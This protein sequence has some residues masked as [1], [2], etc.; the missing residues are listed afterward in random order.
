LPKAPRY[1]LAVSGG[2][3]SMGLARL[4]ADARESVEAIA[5]ADITVLTVDHGLRAAAAEAAARV[6]RWSRQL[7]F[8]HVPLHCRETLPT[9]WV[10]AAARE[11]RYRL[12]TEW[13]LGQG[14]DVL[15]VAHTLDDQAETVLMRLARG[16]GVDGLSAM[17][18]LVVQ[19]GVTVA[20]PLLG[21]SRNDIRSYLAALDQPWIEDPSNDDV[22]FERVRVRNALPALADLG[23]TPQA[24]ATTARRLQRARAM[25]DGA[26]GQAMSRH[27]RAYDAGFCVVESALLSA[28]HEE[29]VLRVLARCL[30]AVGGEPY[31]PRQAALEGLLEALSAGPCRRTLAGCAIGQTDEAITITRE[32][33]R[34]P[35]QPLALR[36]GRPALWDRRFRVCADVGPD[37]EMAQNGIL[38]RPLD[39]QAWTLLKDKGYTCPKDLRDSLVSFWQDDALLAV[40]HLCYRMEALHPDSQFT[41]DFCN[42]VL[43]DGAERCTLPCNRTP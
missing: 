41:A 4:I 14:A 42:F 23:L 19:N 11:E 3:D 25:L 18:P 10:Q 22:R 31:P 32:A 16:S 5:D 12:M 27:V 21:V 37:G 30:C 20:R 35:D 9:S 33:G 2:S 36:A 24:L 40:P 6:G 17:A 28:E 34:M 13:C 43:L 29:I 39:A 8:D 1:A 26:A 15:L 7:G 38:V